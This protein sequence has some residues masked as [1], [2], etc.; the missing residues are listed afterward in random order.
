MIYRSFRFRLAVFF[1]LALVFM[2]AVS[3]FLIS[4][5]ALS[6]QLEQLKQNLVTVATLAASFAD[7]KKIDAVPLSSAAYND[8]NYRSIISKLSLLRNDVPRAEYVYILK[9][10][11]RPNILKFVADLDAPSGKKNAAVPGSDYDATTVPEMMNAFTAPT[12]DDDI[13]ADEWG[14]TLSAYAPIRDASGRAVA[15]LGVDMSAHDVH[16]AQKEIRFRSIAVLL[17]GMLLSILI[18]FM[19]SGGVTRSLRSLTEGARHIAKG[20]LD[21]QVVVRGKD[22]VA[23]L[24]NTFNKMTKDL[25]TYI[26]ELKR[27]TAEREK[28]HKELE[29]AHGIQQSFLP[30]SAPVIDGFDIAA[31]TLPAREVGGDFYDFIPMS[32]GAWGLVVA[33]VSGKGIPAALFMA[34]SRTLIRAS[35]S[36]QTSADDSLKK[37]NKMICQDS[38]S[39]MFVT[40]FYAILR[41]SDKTFE[42]ANAGHNPPMMLSET[43]NSFTLLKAQGTPL[44][45][46][47]TLDINMT[48]IGLK[49]GDLIVL[50]TD[51]VTEA[52]NAAKERFELDRLSKAVFESQAL[53]AKDIIAAIEKRLEE[54]VGGE[55]QFDD[56]T[57][58]VL[59]VK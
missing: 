55:P 32:G 49:S 35:A 52:A 11:D 19:V 57:I 44:G 17:V 36:G 28:L 6:S 14:A 5:Y 33:D 48:K 43:G 12:S 31:M 47:D 21:Y 54:F 41:G 53:P 26:D 10:T 18:A 42:Y 7:P 23:E 25:I 16:N 13:I 38:H 29:I 50:Y 3:N 1:V 45:M 24:G 58:M 27:T 22:E 8:E 59:K 56:M 34:L 15:I 4:K 40:I 46:L 51:G 9:K 30:L 2:S 37:A 20:Q 39:H